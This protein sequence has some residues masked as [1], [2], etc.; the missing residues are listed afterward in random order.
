M[1]WHIMKNYRQH[2]L[3]RKL[4]KISVLRHS[5]MMKNLVIALCSYTTNVRHLCIE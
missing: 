4:G 2:S 1:G 3:N 5:G